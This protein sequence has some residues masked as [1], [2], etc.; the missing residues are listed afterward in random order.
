[1]AER[2]EPNEVCEP[3]VLNRPGC[4]HSFSMK[5]NLESFFRHIHH[6][7][8][9]THYKVTSIP[10][11]LD[12]YTGGWSSLAILFNS[13]QV[14]SIIHGKKKLIV[15]QRNFQPWGTFSKTIFW[16][17]WKLDWYIFFF[18]GCKFGIRLSNSIAKRRMNVQIKIQIRR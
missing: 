7:R 8:W 2:C 16:D 17:E 9:D 11:Y 3:L 13:I 14:V 10:K 4:N 1:M 12:N 15:L 18:F 5:N 6:I